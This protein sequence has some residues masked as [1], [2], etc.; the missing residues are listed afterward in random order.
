LM[1]LILLVCSTTKGVNI[2]TIPNMIPNKTEIVIK[3]E[4]TFGILNF[5]ILNLSKKSQMGF[6]IMEIIAAIIK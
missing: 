5:P 6:P 3:E 4:S 1:L 2:L